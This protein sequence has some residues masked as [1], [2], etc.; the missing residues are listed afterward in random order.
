MSE[1]NN[2]KQCLDI[3]TLKEITGSDNITEEDVA[4]ILS[5]MN[6]SQQEEQ[7]TYMKPPS[8]TSN[9]HSRVGEKYQAVIPEFNPKPPTL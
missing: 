7:Q 8:T 5:S 2:K 6:K 4:D 3:N 1:P 9:K